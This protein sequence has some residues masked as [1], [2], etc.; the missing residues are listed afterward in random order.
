MRNV[1]FGLLAI[2]CAL[3]LTS[4][5]STEKHLSQ[6]KNDV[7]EFAI[8]VD[9]IISDKSEDVN[10]KIDTVKI[11]LDALIQVESRGD[12]LII[13]D[14]GKAVGVLQIHPITVRDVN[15]ILEKRGDTIRYTYNDRTSQKKSI[16]M[17]YIWK[18]Y[19]HLESDFETIARCWNG[20]PK[21][22]N[23][24]MTEYYWSKVEDELNEISS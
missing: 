23:K 11:L 5:T 21:G 22:M 18:S 4:N 15:R 24:P 9:S 16:E 3:I 17:F 1:L 20:G 13:G 2:N 14:N 10:I 19:Y 6:I 8:E 7:E 12:S